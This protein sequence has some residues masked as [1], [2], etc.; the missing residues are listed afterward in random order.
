MPFGAVLGG[1]ASAA[2]GSL[3]SGALGGSKGPA[4]SGSQQSGGSGISN[5]GGGYFHSPSLN[6]NG[7]PGAAGIYISP[8]AQAYLDSLTGATN[9]ANSGLTDLLGKVDPTYGDLVNSQVQSL[10]N[11]KQSSISNLNRSLAQRRILGSSFGQDAVNR[12]ALDYDNQISQ[13]KAQGVLES[14]SATSQILNQRLTNSQALATQELGQIQFDTTTG[15][16]LVNGTQQTFADNSQVLAQ[17]AYANSQGIGKAIQPVASAVGNAVSGLLSQP[18]DRAERERHL[19][20]HAG[21]HSWADWRSRPFVQSRRY[22]R[23]RYGARPDAACRH[24]CVNGRR[25][26]DW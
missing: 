16:N 1:V 12:T 20:L 11:A 18:T 19:C 13:A 24:G 23:H 14:I 7:S 21:R 9:T 6:F 17:L 8:Q 10:Q 5:F 15:V 3:L 4:I 2:T 22:R 26:C 25:C